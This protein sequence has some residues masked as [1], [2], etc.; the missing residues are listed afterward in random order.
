MGKKERQKICFNT[1]IQILSDDKSLI[2]LKKSLPLHNI[3]CAVE[4]GCKLALV[5]KCGNAFLLRPEK[6][7]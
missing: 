5:K 6:M 1:E 4:T 7:C 2:I 3:L